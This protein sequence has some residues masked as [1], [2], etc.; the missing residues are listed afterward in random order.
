MNPADI[1]WKN[2]YQDVGPVRLRGIFDLS[3]LALRSLILLNGAAL[4][5]LFLLARHGQPQTALSAVWAAFWLFVS[6][7]ALA[8]YAILVGSLSHSAILTAE[9]FAAE[10]TYQEVI[11]GRPE[12]RTENRVRAVNRYLWIAIA[13]ACA[14]LMVFSAGAAVS[15][16][17]LT[18]QTDDADQP[19]DDPVVLPVEAGRRGVGPPVQTRL[20]TRV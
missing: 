10:K 1:G 9:T 11:A 7:L 3:L 15:L 18:V 14:S 5:A 17:A 19:D 2:H 13:A 6:G 8:M 12:V 16:N 4:A 20:L